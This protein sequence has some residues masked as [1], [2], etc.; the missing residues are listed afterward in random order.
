MIL[1]VIRRPTPSPLV[2]QAAVLPKDVK[3]R[4]LEHCGVLFPPT[5]VPHGVK[6]RYDGVELDLTPEQEELAGFY[7][8]AL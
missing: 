7:A 4:T 3:W 8:S 6:M 2:A 1:C 5:Y